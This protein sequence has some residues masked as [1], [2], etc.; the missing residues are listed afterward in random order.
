[1]TT[2]LIT[3]ANK[4]LGFETARQLIAA[5]HTVYIGARDEGRGRAAADRLGARY[6]HL[7]VTDDDSVA[8]AV[9]TVEAGGGLD[10]LINNAGIE[11]R[12]PDNG[13][14]AAADTTAAQIRTI[15]ETNVFGL[16]R[17][18]HAFL[19]LLQKSTAPVIVNL[20]SGLASLSALSNPDSSTHFYPGVSYP[21]SKAAV[22]AITIQYAKAFPQLRVNAVEPGYTNTDLN[23]GTGTQTV[24]EG[25]E[26]IVRMAQ[27]GADGPTGTFVSAHGPLAW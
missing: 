10:V 5:G 25:A 14:V 4:G 15:F 9:A 6:V 3:G 13:I 24:E 1:M 20:S 12:L 27:L 19:P 16:V 18:T 11:G 22:N 8:A 17:V 26:I 7:D 23:G 2:T 21:A